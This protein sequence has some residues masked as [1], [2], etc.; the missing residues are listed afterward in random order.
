MIALVTF[1][2]RN[3][4]GDGAIG[5]IIIKPIHV[6]TDIGDAGVQAVGFGDI[7]PSLVINAKRDRVGEQGFGG[8]ESNLEAFG[9]AK[10]LNGQFGFVRSRRDNRRVECAGNEIR[11]GCFDPNDDKDKNGPGAGRNADRLQHCRRILERA[12]GVA[13]RSIQPVTHGRT[14]T[15]ARRK[16]E[17]RGSPLPRTSK[18]M[19]TVRGA[20]TPGATKEMLGPFVAGSVASPWQ[21]PASG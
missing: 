9:N 17:S 12:D 14:S 13:R 3:T 2:H 21:V 7:K 1:H 5:Q 6:A 15:T 16:A 11:G 4:I 18:M 8:E 10:A 20:G 19:W